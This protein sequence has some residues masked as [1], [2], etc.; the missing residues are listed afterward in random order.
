MGLH[1]QK[2]IYQ[3]RILQDSS[4]LSLPDMFCPLSMK[5]SVALIKFS[6][7]SEHTLVSRSPALS[8]GAGSTQ[9]QTG[10]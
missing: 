1:G 5:S 10:K 4:L 7:V 6:E 3:R 2:V 9:Q 8:A